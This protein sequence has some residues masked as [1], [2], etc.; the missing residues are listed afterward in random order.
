MS[1]STD[2]A[3]N[4]TGA[5]NGFT[6]FLEKASPGHIHTWCYAHVLNLVICDVT[7]SNEASVTLFGILQKA[8]VF[9]RVILENGPLD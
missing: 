5:Y 9:S 4:M 6:A 3:S 1:D 2:V 8:A 7:G